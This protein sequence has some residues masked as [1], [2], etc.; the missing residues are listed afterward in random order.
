MVKN[1]LPT[2]ALTTG[3][4]LWKDDDGNVDLGRMEVFGDEVLEV[5]NIETN[6]TKFS[7]TVSKLTS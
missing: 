4:R 6:N 7:D 1:D 3:E 5:R 2:I